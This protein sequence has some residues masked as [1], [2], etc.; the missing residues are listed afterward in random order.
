MGHTKKYK[1]ENFREGVTAEL[2]KTLVQ[3]MSRAESSEFV[4]RSRHR[5]LGN[6]TTVLTQKII[7]PRQSEK[8][9]GIVQN[10]KLIKKHIYVI[11]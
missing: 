2:P 10:K 7:N 6:E 8:K 5:K 1:K 4:S 9:L 3:V 11:T